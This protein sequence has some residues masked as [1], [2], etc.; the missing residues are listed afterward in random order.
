[1][2]RKP[3]F[4][5]PEA[6]LRQLR[7][8]G[9]YLHEMADHFGCST[10]TVL[11]ACRRFGIDSSRQPDD[12]NHGNRVCSDNRGYVRVWMP[13]H[14][15]AKSDGY[16]L[17]HRLVMEQV[18]G[19]PLLPGENVHHKN[20]VKSDNRPENLVLFSSMSEHAR[21]EHGGDAVHRLCIGCRM[22]RSAILASLEGG[23]PLP[24]PK[25][26]KSKNRRERDVRAACEQLKIP[27]P[28]WCDRLFGPKKEQYPPVRSAPRISKSHRPSE[29]AG[30]R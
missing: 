25:S 23:D 14:P 22:Q 8:R 24:L 6:E 27:V 2:P 18:I 3:D 30:D 21:M 26:R 16:I 12:R 28:A 7:D 5:L 13:D 1:M 19:R 11:R 4:Q 9:K 10:R 15:G 17:E 29:S 20:R